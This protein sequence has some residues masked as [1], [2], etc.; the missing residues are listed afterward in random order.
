MLGAWRPATRRGHGDVTHAAPI[1]YTRDMLRGALLFTGLLACTPAAPAAKVEPTRTEPT[2]TDATKTAPSTECTAK[3]AAMRTLFAHGPG[4]PPVVN[5]LEGTQL[6]E[7]SRGAPIVEG[8][9]LFI[10]ADGSFDF[11]GQSFA[12]VAAL[13]EVL[14][15]DFDRGMQLAKNM[16]RPWQ[17]RLLLV[18]DAR[19]PATVIRDLAATV[20]LETTFAVIATLAGDT[21]PTAPPIPAPVQE[22]LVVRAD[23]RSQ[24]LAELLT[25]AI[26]SCTP[27]ADVFQA[28]ATTTSDNRSKVLLDGLPGAIEACRCEG[29]DVETVTA[30][31]WSMSGKLGPDMREIG[32]PLAG[33]REAAV[34]LVPATATI[35]DLVRLAD[36][37]P[38]AKP[39]RFAKK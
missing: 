33:S 15:E 34:V 23:L 3:V 12:T 4:D 1:G 7:T 39:F 28:V 2:S 22:A 8:F 14:T 29:I 18:A 30:V 19:A 16:D 20:P 10:R 13:D 32:I 27:A 21:V 17:P 11:N 37:Q 24:K 31:V 26:G 38:T 35:S 5:P 9:P 6:P 36:A 25:T